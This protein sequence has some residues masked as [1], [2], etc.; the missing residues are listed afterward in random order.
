MQGDPLLQYFN[1]LR[2]KVIHQDAPAIGIVLASA[3]TMAP[4]VGSITIEDVP[5]PKNHLGKGIED[6]SMTNLCKLY[7][8]YLDR[9]F[10]A[11]APVAFEVQERLLA[12]ASQPPPDS[13]DNAA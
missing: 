6:T 10:E 4:P 5:L 9:M 13:G 11:F 3:G 12:E 7:H 1:N 8:A 2:R